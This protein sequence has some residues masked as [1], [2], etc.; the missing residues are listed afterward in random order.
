MRHPRGIRWG[1]GHHDYADLDAFSSRAAAASLKQPAVSRC[2]RRSAVGLSGARQFALFSSDIALI[3]WIRLSG[4]LQAAVSTTSHRAVV[5]TRA[6][7]DSASSRHVD[8]A[9]NLS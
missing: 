5:T 2:C 7:G 3:Q 1:E 8:G 9:S 6:A 4:E